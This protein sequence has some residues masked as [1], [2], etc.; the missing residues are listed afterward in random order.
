[1]LH[2]PRTGSRCTWASARN[3]TTNALRTR[4]IG[5]SCIRTCA[6]QRRVAL[7]RRL[8]ARQEQGY[9]ARAADI[10]TELAVHFERG[11]DAERAVQYLGAAA[12]NASR[13]SAHREAIASHAGLAL[14]TTLP[15]AP[16][17]LQQELSMQ[18]PL[19][20]ALLAS[21]GW[22]LEVEH[23]YARAR[24]LCQQVGEPLDS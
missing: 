23:T 14:L 24:E 20:R 8:G 1:M 11:R 19:A 4:S 3:C 2:L 10:A 17:R 22:A 6:G 9:G 7:H 5:M 18:I 13:R 12:E 21:K 15:A 16:D